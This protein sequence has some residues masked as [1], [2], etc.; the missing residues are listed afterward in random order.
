MIKAGIKGSDQGFIFEDLDV[1]FVGQVQKLADIIDV[2]AG[3][4]LA[5]ILLDE[6][7]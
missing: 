5:I 4:G 7:G 3:H 6:I 2:S 1:F